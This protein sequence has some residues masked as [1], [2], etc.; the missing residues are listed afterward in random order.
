MS[1]SGQVLDNLD[2]EEKAS[3]FSFFAHRVPIV[4]LPLE[5]ILS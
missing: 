2:C 5:V 4:E 3:N 1:F